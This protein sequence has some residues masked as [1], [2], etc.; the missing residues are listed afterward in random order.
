[1]DFFQTFF[2]K[3]NP[4]LCKSL[5]CVIKNVCF[6]KCLKEIHSCAPSF[7]PR[8]AT[9]QRANL[10]RTS[11]D[12]TWIRMYGTHFFKC[13]EQFNSMT[14]A[15]HFFFLRKDDEARK[16]ITPPLRSFAYRERSLAS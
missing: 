8:R 15:A 2:K 12:L 6:E 5:T 3:T 16:H 13:A 1:M 7:N 11:G 14:N 10:R 9:V 4:L